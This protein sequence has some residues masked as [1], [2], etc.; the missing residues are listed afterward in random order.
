MIWW[1]FMTGMKLYF[2]YLWNGSHVPATGTLLK[3]TSTSLQE[4]GV[5]WVL[6]ISHR[7][8]SL[9]ARKRCA[10]IV[11]LFLPDLLQLW[12]HKLFCDKWK[13]FVVGSCIIT[14]A[15]TTY[16]VLVL[17]KWTKDRLKLQVLDILWRFEHFLCKII[18]SGRHC[19]SESWH[20][21]WNWRL[22][23][24]VSITSI[25]Q[26]RWKQEKRTRQ[27]RNTHDQLLVLS[28]PSMILSLQVESV[29][30]M[31][32]VSPMYKSKKSTHDVVGSNQ[33]CEL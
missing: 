11:R 15:F 7:I 33:S 14:A 12:C 25:V 30:H 10:D 22:S 2:D 18:H 3:C 32:W 13:R 19:R 1:W 21:S 27:E 20:R 23:T 9:N 4:V 8:R 31:D 17:R 24:S 6:N 16:E 29:F 5:D 28:S 26:S